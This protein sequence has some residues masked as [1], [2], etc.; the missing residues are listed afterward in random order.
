MA[1]LQAYPRHSKLEGPRTQIIEIYI[2]GLGFKGSKDPPKKVL[3]PKYDNVNCIWAIKLYYL[4]PWTL[5]ASLQII[6]TLD[7]KVYRYGGWKSCTIQLI[8]P[9]PKK[10]MQQQFQHYTGV[11][12]GF[13]HPQECLLGYSEPLGHGSGFRV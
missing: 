13:L 7:T 4:G 12:E 6:P 2:L 3:G 9:P 5:R 11:V 8:H 10:V 1:T